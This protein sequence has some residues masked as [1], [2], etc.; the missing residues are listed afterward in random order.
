[1]LP[2][3]AVEYIRTNFLSPHAPFQTYK[4]AA[5]VYAQRGF[6]A[7]YPLAQPIIDKL[8]VV[9]AENQGFVGLAVAVAV[10]TV[11]LMVLNWI[12]RLAMWCAW[13]SVRVVMMSIAVA[14]GAYVWERG[15][16]DTAQSLFVLGGKVM[17]Y[18]A[19]LK[20]VWLDEYSKYEEQ[21][22]MSGTRGG[23]SGR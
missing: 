1:M 18:L 21:Q 19:V 16:F 10:V 6:D 3:E 22:T 23:R 15:L 20:N 13:A 7:L 4:R 5:L 14:V 8:L 9:M 2:P 11:M 17:G 12:R